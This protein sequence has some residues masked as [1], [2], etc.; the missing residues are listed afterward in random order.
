[1][2]DHHQSIHMGSYLHVCPLSNVRAEYILSLININKDR[3]GLHTSSQLTTICNSIRTVK[4]SRARAS[5]RNWLLGTT[6]NNNVS[7]PI[8]SNSLAHT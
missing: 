6:H 8:D 7:N 3:I 4:S 2:S 1:M 5:T